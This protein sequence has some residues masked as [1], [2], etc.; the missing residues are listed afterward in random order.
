MV[1]NQPS[2]DA[3]QQ[4]GNKMLEHEEHQKVME[5]RENGIRD[6]KISLSLSLIDKGDCECGAAD[7]YVS[8]VPEVKTSLSMRGMPKVMWPKIAAA[9]AVATSHVIKDMAELLPE[10]YRKA[11]YFAL[12]VETRCGCGANHIT[13]FLVMPKSG[14]LEKHSDV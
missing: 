10:D 14:A 6:T 12:D 8:V 9:L 2:E 11:F 13:D 4:K 7:C 5:I 1:Q 3:C